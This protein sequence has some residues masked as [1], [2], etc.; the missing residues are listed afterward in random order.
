MFTLLIAAALAPDAA[1]CSPAEALPIAS[2]PVS[3]ASD[4]ELNQRLLIEFSGGS[5]ADDY[6]I[7][8]FDATSEAPIEGQL[9]IECA[10]QG[11]FSDPCMAIF[12]PE[13]GNWPARSDIRWYIQPEW[14]AADSSDTD[15]YD[16]YG[17][18]STSDEYHKGYA[19]QS[20]LLT[21]DFTE[22]IVA[23]GMCEDQDRLLG[24]FVLE[25]DGLEAGSLVEL[26]V[27]VESEEEN[28]RGGLPEESIVDLVILEETGPF[29]LELHAGIPAT[30]EYACYSARV[31]TAD[32][33]DYAQV[34]GPCLQWEDG[35][36]PEMLCGTGLGFGL[37]CSTLLVSD[38]LSASWLGLL[39]LV[40]LLRRQ[41]R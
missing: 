16:L 25:G 13:R 20:L 15:Y 35:E 21:G 40:T 17:R 18:F 31:F 28:S 24:E 39:G 5:G 37:G 41:R 23:D 11:G 14:L 4:V 1:A 19:A 27:S 10:N 7:Q 12:V 30:Y 36:S 3:E 2:Y 38:P 8:V 22:W 34:D 6:G 33:S 9:S 29:S 26:I 32:G